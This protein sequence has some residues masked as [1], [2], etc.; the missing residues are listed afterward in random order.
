MLRL[1][2]IPKFLDL[3]DKY[4]CQYIFSSYWCDS[5]LEYNNLD[6]IKYLKSKNKLVLS[7]D[8][9][10]HVKTIEVLVYC[11]ENIQRLDKRI[12][13][14]DPNW[15]LNVKAD[16]ILIYYLENICSWNNKMLVTAIIKGCTKVVI[17][18][19]KKRITDTK[20]IRKIQKITKTTA[21]YPDINTFLDEHDK[22]QNSE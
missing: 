6:L 12:I 21:T 9:F 16:D 13:E 7:S 1:P 10:A 8:W 20:Y 4:N 17:H 11:S 18:A 14:K 3:L 5:I 15:F 2:N 22:N 19:I